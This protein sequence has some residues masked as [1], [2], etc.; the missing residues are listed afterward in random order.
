SPKQSF[1]EMLDNKLVFSA[2]KP[3]E[4]G[5]G[6]ILRLWNPTGE[7]LS[8]R[9]RLWKKPSSIQPVKLDE[10]TV[11]GDAI[12]P[13]EDIITITAGPHKIITVKIL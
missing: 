11:D 5:D 4:D 6:Q 10:T 13:A 8:E 1:M 3:A 2:F 7:T 12:K 9:I